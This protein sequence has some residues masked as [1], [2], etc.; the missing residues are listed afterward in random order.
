MG[1]E[2]GERGHPPPHGPH[3]PQHGPQHPRHHDHGDIPATSRHR[4]RQ[5]STLNTVPVP[6]VVRA[7][8]PHSFLADPDPAVLLKGDPDPAAF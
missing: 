4:H 2:P 8:D 1:G 3:V 7:V 6:E 5:G